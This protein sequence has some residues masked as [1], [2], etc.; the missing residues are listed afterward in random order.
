MSV[1][2][3]SLA[4]T[5]ACKNCPN[6]PNSEPFAYK[7]IIVGTEIYPTINKSLMKLKYMYCLED[8]EKENDYETQQN[9]L[10]LR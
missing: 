2:C 6:N 8:G 7:T 3:C 1:C 9:S 5:S 4:G 10:L